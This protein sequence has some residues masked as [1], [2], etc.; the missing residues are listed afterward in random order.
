MDLRGKCIE[1]I[2]KLC[3]LFAVLSFL[4]INKQQMFVVVF[5]EPT[6][7]QKMPK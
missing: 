4:E 2:P 6:K 3:T 7:Q 1:E 5:Q